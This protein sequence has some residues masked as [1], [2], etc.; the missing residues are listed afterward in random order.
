MPVDRED[1]SAFNRITFR[2]RPDYPARK[3]VTCIAAVVNDGRVKVPDVYHR[4]GYHVI[5]L[6]NHEWNTVNWEFPDLPAA[7]A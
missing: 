1:W 4:E 3:H 2:I 6:L 5:N 7:T